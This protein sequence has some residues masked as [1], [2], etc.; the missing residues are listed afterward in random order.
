[1]EHAI[2]RHPAAASQ[3]LVDWRIRGREAPLNLLL[4]VDRAV[5]LNPGINEPASASALSVTADL[6]EVVKALRTTAFD[7]EGSKVDYPRLRERMVME[8]QH[9]PLWQILASA[10]REDAPLR[11]TCDEVFTVL[12]YVAE[13]RPKGI[14]AERLWQAAREHLACCPECGERHLRQLGILELHLATRS[15]AGLDRQRY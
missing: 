9:R 14:A 11:L 3:R 6:I 5:V 12:E 1:M 13:V 15:Q 8:A 10:T 7:L 2:A 4:R